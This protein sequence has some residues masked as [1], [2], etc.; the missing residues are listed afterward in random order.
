[1]LRQYRQVKAEHPNA[2][3]MFRLGDFYEMFYDDAVVASKALSL[4]LTARHRGS[5]NEAPMCGVP[6]HAAEGYI[7]RLVRQGHRVAICDQIEDAK[8]ARGIVKR[9]VTRVVSPGTVTDPSQLQER[10]PNYIAALLAAGT[11]AR[12][13]PTDGF[14]CAYLDLSTGEF[15]LSEHRGQAAT[16]ALRDEVAA[17]APKEIVQPEGTS[18]EE[19][20]APETL[21]RSLISDA[22]SWTFARDTAYETLL[23]RFGTASLDG[24]GCAKSRSAPREPSSVTCRIRRKPTSS[25][26]PALPGTRPRRG[27]CSTPPPAGL[28]RW[29]RTAATEDAKEPCSPFSIGPRPPW[30]AACCAAGSSRHCCRCRASK[31]DWRP[32]AS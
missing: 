26:S 28:S 2:I 14:G 7:A 12:G 21:E 15:R 27:W 24:F 8:Q 18:L 20:L 9:A 19:V 5:P 17:F 29:W 22:P 25:M 1:M 3:L 6:F 31:S 32:S 10:E 4:A 30:A 13:R 16:E 11:P 23:G